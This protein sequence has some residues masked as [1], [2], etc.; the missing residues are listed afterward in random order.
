LNWNQ[1]DSLKGLHFL[2]WFFHRVGELRR[3]QPRGVW[4]YTCR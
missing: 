2:D 3:A 1:P 4:F